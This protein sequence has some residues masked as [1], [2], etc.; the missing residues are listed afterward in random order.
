LIRQAF[1]VQDSQ[2][3]GGPAWLEADRY[4]IEAKTGSPEKLS[5]DQLGPLMQNLP[6]ERFG[7]KFHRETRE[8][9]VLALLVEKGGPKLKTESRR[10][11]QQAQI[12]AVAREKRTWLRLVHR[13]S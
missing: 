3:V 2:I 1:R 6:A 7:L 13:W 8:M 9:P 10:R 4:D 11:G 12:Q 5:R